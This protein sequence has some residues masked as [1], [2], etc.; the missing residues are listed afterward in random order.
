MNTLKTW[1]AAAALLALTGAA[2]AALIPQSSLSGDTT[3]KDDTTNLVW[4]KDW[5]SGGAKTWAAADTW[6]SGLVYGGYDDW[7][8]PEI[9]E[10]QAL[11][12]AAGSTQTKLNVYFVAPTG[13]YWANTV[14]VSPPEPDFG[15]GPDPD[16]GFGPGS[17]PPESNEPRRQSFNT[18]DRGSTGYSFETD[19]LSTM[20]VRTGSVTAAVPEP[21]SMALAGLA[22]IGLACT[23]RRQR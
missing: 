2:Q 13:D 1:A 20:A 17:A 7:R 18:Y 3:V 5:T 21:S 23:R 22:L 16:P 14:Y 15:L 6:A 9:G 10:Y 12:A 8:L 4:L 11:W 19:S